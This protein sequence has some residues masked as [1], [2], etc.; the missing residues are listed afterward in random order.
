MGDVAYTQEL[1]A[2]KIIECSSGKVP[3]ALA[4]EL[5][6]KLINWLV[7]KPRWVNFINIIAAWR[8][9]QPISDKFCII[10]DWQGNTLSYCLKMGFRFMGTPWFKIMCGI[11]NGMCQPH[12]NSLVHGDLKPSNSLSRH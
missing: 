9:T 1:Y 12:L 11:A 5:N 4:V 7:S 3:A 6:E 8:E 10:M 2:V